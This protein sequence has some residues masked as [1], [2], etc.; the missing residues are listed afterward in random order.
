M[1]QIACQTEDGNN[2]IF[3]GTNLDTGDSVSL[4]QSCLIEFFAAMLEGMTGIP[5]GAIMAAGLSQLEDA[6]QQEGGELMS[7]EQPK[8]PDVPN[9]EREN[10]HEEHDVPDDEPKEPDE[11]NGDGEKGDDSSDSADK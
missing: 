8:E 5:V 4:C 11:V 7:D 6:Q 3:I 1:A 9:D 2:A 10:L